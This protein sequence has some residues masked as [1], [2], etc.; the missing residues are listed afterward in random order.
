MYGAIVS[1]KT[2][3]VD[4]KRINNN[5]PNKY[6]WVV[7]VFAYASGFLAVHLNVSI[8]VRFAIAAVLLFLQLISLRHAATILLLSLFL[9]FFSPLL[10]E[11]FLR[12]NRLAIFPF[13]FMA[14]QKKS[15]RKFPANKQLLILALLSIVLIRVTADLQTIFQISNDPTHQFYNKSLKNYLADYYDLFTG[16]FLIYMVYLKMSLDDLRLFFKSLLLIGSLM[17]LSILYI[18]VT[19]FGAVLSHEKGVLWD[20][21]LFTHKQ[22]WGPLMFILFLIFFIIYFDAKKKS[23]VLLIPLV[24][25]IAAVMVSLSR[26]AYI[27]VVLGIVLYGVLGNNFKKLIYIFGI[28]LLL[29]PVVLQFDFV[30]ERMESIVA[31]KDVNEFQS[32]SAGHFSDKAINQYISN[33]TFAPQI[34]YTDWEFNYSEG[35]WNGLLHQSGIIGFLIVAS[36][37][38][39]LIRRYNFLHKVGNP[40]T[41]TLALSG[42]II[43]I[44]SIIVNLI[45]RHVYFIHYYGYLTGIS[46]LLMILYLTTEISYKEDTEI[47]LN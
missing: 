2:R 41:K 40:A 17:A 10:G 28:M 25:T 42:L 22:Y 11:G 1:N 8:S 34:F 5:T 14:L 30:R 15:L 16:L 38:F 4:E 19:N 12:F 21:P 37:Y 24:L 47:M 44:L 3:P 43:T 46:L 23:L 13:A 31:A 29:F 32:Q 26:T 33:F 6:W 27:A 45:V 20:S 35:F 7:T 39:R 18:A 9:P 36:V